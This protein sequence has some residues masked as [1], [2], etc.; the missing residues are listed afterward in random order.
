MAKV[1]TAGNNDI[2]RSEMSQDLAGNLNLAAK[3][4]GQIKIQ[5]DFIIWILN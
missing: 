4:G 1:A 3:T 5:I 2:G